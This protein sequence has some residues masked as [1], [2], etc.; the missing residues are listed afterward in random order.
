MLLFWWVWQ[1][2][3]HVFMLLEGGGAAWRNNGGELLE[4]PS[5][6]KKP[7]I[8]WIFRN[9]LGVL[10]FQNPKR[11]CLFFFFFNLLFMF[12]C[13]SCSY[14]LSEKS[15]RDF[16]PCIQQRLFNHS[17]FLFC[18]DR[19]SLLVTP[20]L[21]FKCSSICG[22]ASLLVCPK[23]MIFKQINCVL[24]NIWRKGEKKRGKKEKGSPPFTVHCLRD[25]RLSISGFLVVRWDETILEIL[26][27]GLQRSCC[28]LHLKTVITLTLALLRMR[29]RDPTTCRLIT[30]VGNSVPDGRKDTI[31]TR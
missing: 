22:T 2:L 7:V 26:S 8:V 18:I 25:V 21:I 23:Q 20:Q 28:R 17:L 16:S 30:S 9:N 12:F 14:F 1:W 24:V 4:C 10:N 31:R 5:R 27:A 29:G 19:Y 11:F 6:G 15:P 3:L 13:C